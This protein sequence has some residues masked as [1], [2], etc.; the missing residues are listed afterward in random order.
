MVLLTVLHDGVRGYSGQLQG[1]V[2]M[3]KEIGSRLRLKRRD[4]LLVYSNGDVL[5]SERKKVFLLFSPPHLGGRW[6]R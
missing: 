4:R 3:P 2:V 5:K 1:Q 6:L